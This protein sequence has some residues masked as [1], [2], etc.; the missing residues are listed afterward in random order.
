MCV[1]FARTGDGVGPVVF[2]I[3]RDVLV[4]KEAEYLQT[5]TEISAEGEEKSQSQR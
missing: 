1:Y 2:G 5:D 3:P 4:S